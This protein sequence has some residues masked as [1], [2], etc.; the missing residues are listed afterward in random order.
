MKLTFKMKVKTPIIIENF[1]KEIIIYS[2]DKNGN[3]IKKIDDRF[4]PYFY[5]EDKK[6]NYVSIDGKKLRRVFVNLPEK[7]KKVR[8]KYEKQGKEV[9]EADIKYSIRY[10]ID[11]FPTPWEKTPIRICYFD[12]EVQDSL[13]YINVPKPIVSIT[14]YDNFDKKYYIFA[15][16]NS[17]KVYKIKDGYILEFDSEERMLEK[18]LSFIS[19]KD[20]DLLLAWNIEYDINYL[21]N[22]MEKLGINYNRLSRLDKVVKIQNRIVKVYG[23]A[24]VDLMFLYTKL[25]YQRERFES[26]EKVANEEDLGIKKLQRKEISKMSFW[27]IVAYNKRDVEI[28]VKLDKKLSI[29]DFWDELRRFVGLAWN[30]FVMF[31]YKISN[32]RLVDVYLLRLAK[33]KGIVLPT[34]KQHK[35]KPYEGALVLQPP[36]GIF[37]NVIVLDVKSMY[38]NIIR[39]YNLSPE[40]LDS[41]GE[42]LTPLGYKFKKEPIGLIPEACSELF[43]LRKQYKKK[44]KEYLEQGNEEKVK[45]YD[46][47]QTA[48]KIIL[49]SLYGVMAYKNFRLF[50]QEIAETVTAFGRELLRHIINVVEFNGYKVLYSDTDSVFVKLPDDWP[51]EKCL[52]EAQRLIEIINNSFNEFARKWNVN[53]HY[54]EIELKFIFDRIAFFG[55]KKRYAGYYINEE[56]VWKEGFEIKGLQI[57]RSDSAEITKEVLNKVLEKILVKGKSPENAIEYINQIMEEIKNEKIPIEKLVFKVSFDPNKKYKNKNIPFL[58]GLKLAK[59]LGLIDTLPSG[60]IVWIYIKHPL[61]DTIAVPEDKIDL[62]KDFVIDYP[63][64]KDRWF[65]NIIDLLNK[66]KNSNT[67]NNLNKIIQK[68]EI[69]QKF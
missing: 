57:V 42:I 69:K 12:I 53:K 56:S 7:V 63:K 38:P 16:G 41:N 3:L 17:E 58:R 8:K 52:E 35:R 68:V 15:L 28:M 61:N 66:L 25:K 31:D 67:S 9:Y 40:T 39:T 11:K 43:E 6:G 1:G 34:A 48:V 45:E 59:Q 27:E 22:R 33:R 32:K 47:K 44:M 65:G 10:T 2:R 55:V 64:C 49:N 50:K 18:F 30:D 46:N 29:I 4:Y 51:K 26:L 20:P 24:L 60:K 14:A 37:K 19:K 5:V 54:H 36:I 21:V 13:D 62:I 23:R